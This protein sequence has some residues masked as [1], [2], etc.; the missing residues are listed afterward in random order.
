MVGSH[1]WMGVREDGSRLTLSHMSAIWPLC[2]FWI[3]KSISK[4]I[5]KGESFLCLAAEPCGKLLSA[6]A[7]QVR[8]AP[9]ISTD[10]LGSWKWWCKHK[11]NKRMQWKV[12]SWYLVAWYCKDLLVCSPALCFM[13]TLIWMR[14]PL[15]GEAVHVSARSYL[16]SSNLWCKAEKLSFVSFKLQGGIVGLYLDV[17]GIFLHIPQQ[18]PLRGFQDCPRPM[19]ECHPFTDIL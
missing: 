13:N 3:W 2:M 18:V 1:A 15:C 11:W 17:I 19:K 7:V 14:F 5:A 6:G 8:F 16:V 9:V 10:T 12:L 4:K